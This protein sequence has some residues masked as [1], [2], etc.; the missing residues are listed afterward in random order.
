MNK[1]CIMFDCMETLI[2]M[3]ELPSQRD[4]ALWA[5]KGSG[6]EEYF[7]DFDNFFISFKNARET[8]LSEIPENKEFTFDEQYRYIVEEK[9]DDKKK[10]E[11]AVELLLKNFWTNYKKRC[12]VK[13]EI[14]DAL[15][16]LK[17]RYNLGVVSNFKIK[18]GI[19]ELLEYTE[20]SGFF[21]FVINSADIGWRKPHSYIYDYAV[22]KSGFK[23]DEIVFIGDSFTNDYEGPRKAGIESILLDKGKNNDNA[24][25]NCRK[26]E[27]FSELKRIL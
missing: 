6:C 5:F 15:G 3:T 10:Q 18:G 22:K 9:I 25:E 7:K 14:K 27:H 11:R 2:D 21:K 19:E 4:Y 20:I 8:I 24:C 13:K 1:K 16:Y 12:F 17:S 26:I 23:K